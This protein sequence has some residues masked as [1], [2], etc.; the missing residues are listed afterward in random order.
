MKILA[1]FPA[2]SVFALGAA[3][4]ALSACASADVA[5]IKRMEQ[6]QI[7]MV[8]VTEINVTVETPKPHP[9]L[10]VFLN[11]E[12]TKAMPNCATGDVPY[13][14]N[15]AVVDFEDQD[16]AKSIFIGDEIELS[17]RVE[18]LDASTKEKVGEY[19][20]DRSFFWGG[21]VGAAMMSDAE[22][23]LSEGFAESVCEEVF[24]VA[25]KKDT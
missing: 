8:K 24:G 2:R 15:V 25:P 3:A 10:K 9:Q 13:V 11:E 22:R 23:S 4:F 19:F 21:F 17:G 14:L 5:A 18:L 6:D 20:V 7:Q 16:V 1:G 12:L